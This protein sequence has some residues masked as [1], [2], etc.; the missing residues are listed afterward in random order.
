MDGLQER[1]TRIDPGG[2]MR[3][4]AAGDGGMMDGSAAGTDMEGFL[5]GVERQAYVMARAMT[6]DAEEAMDIVQDTML[7]FVRRY[8]RRPEDQWRPLFFRI[9]VNRVRDTHR[10]RAVRARVMSWFR[11]ERQPDPV[12]V[13]PAGR[14]SDPAVT[15]Q[16]QEAMVALQAAME[17]LPARQQQAFALRCLEGMD[18]ATTARV[19]GCS[20]G[21]VK[22]HYSRALAALRPKLGEYRD[23]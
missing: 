4:P 6:G 16:G 1:N 21:S 11:D 18:V 14:A 20:A 17:L 19:M 22:T 23:D 9:L 5:H 3:L 7:R 15:V 13:A 8:S 12:D 10:R 2:P